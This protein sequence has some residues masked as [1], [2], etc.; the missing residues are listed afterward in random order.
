MNLFL[1][2]LYSFNSELALLV[3]LP[4]ITAGDTKWFVGWLL[5]LNNNYH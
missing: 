1:V 2:L 4:L 3:G 5:F